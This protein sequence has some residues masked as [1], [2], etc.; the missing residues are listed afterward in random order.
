MIWSASSVRRSCSAVSGQSMP[1]GT[2]FMASLEPAPRKAR[3]GNITSSV[4]SCWATTT[5]L[6]RHTRPVTPVPIEIVEVAWPAAP[7]HTQALPQWAGAGSPGSHQ[8]VRW[9]LAAMPSKP[10]CSAR[11]AWRSSSSGP[12][13]S[14]EAPRT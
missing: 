11:T 13:R 6:Y 4:A 2:S 5:G 9:S 7:S 14:C 8:G 1:A 10:A 3:P 12:K